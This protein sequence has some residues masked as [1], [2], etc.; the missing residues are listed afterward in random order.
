MPAGEA[1]VKWC[2]ET[3]SEACAWSPKQAQWDSIKKLVS[4]E[5]VATSRAADEGHAET[6]AEHEAATRGLGLSADAPLPSVIY[7]ITSAN[8]DVLVATVDLIHR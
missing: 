4:R 1:L 3:E 8:A 6:P 5:Q 7:M 2:A